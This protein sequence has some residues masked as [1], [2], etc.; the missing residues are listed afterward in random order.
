MGEKRKCDFPMRSCLLCVGRV[1]SGFDTNHAEVVTDDVY[2]HGQL[3]TVEGQVGRV[4]VNRHFTRV[5]PFDQMHDARSIGSVASVAVRVK[6]SAHAVISTH[7]GKFLQRSADPADTVPVVLP[8]RP[9]PVA[10]LDERHA[11][12]SAGR[13]D[14]PHG[15]IF[16]V[17]RISRKRGKWYG[18]SHCLPMFYRLRQRCGHVSRVH[19][20]VV[21]NCHIDAVKPSRRAGIG[22]FANI[23]LYD[24]D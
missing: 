18:K 1:S 11:G 24:L 16:R 14:R 6:E 20:L 23:N 3:L 2:P 12:T 9:W 4:E 8:G 7:C 21:T 5:E 22:D 17:D 10:E 19:A 15:S 13:V